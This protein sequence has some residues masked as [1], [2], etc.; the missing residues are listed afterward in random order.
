MLLSTFGTNHISKT[1]EVT[2]KLYIKMHLH[3]LSTSCISRRRL[4]WQ[5]LT[6]RWQRA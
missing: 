6:G 5:Q 3:Y 1:I 4:W 2:R